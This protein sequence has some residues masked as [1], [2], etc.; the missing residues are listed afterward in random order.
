MGYPNKIGISRLKQQF[1]RIGARLVVT[2]HQAQRLER[3][4]RNRTTAKQ[5][6]WR[7]V[8][9]FSSNVRLDAEGEHFTMI[10]GDNSM[11]PSGKASV[12]GPDLS[13]V[14]VLDIRPKDR[15]LL[16]QVVIGEGKDMQVDKLLMGHDE[17]H[18]FIAQATGST[19]FEA[20]ENLK[21]DIVRE[22]Q[23]R[24]NVKRSKRN[25]RK[26]AAFIRQGEWFFLP[27]PDFFPGKHTIVSANEPLRRGAGKPHMA[28]E[29]CRMGGTTVMFN[30]VYAPEG[31]SMDAYNKLRNE[32]SEDEDFRRSGAW[33]SMTRDAIV[34]VRG[35]IRHP[36]HKTLKLRGWY[37]VV[38]NTEQV[39]TGGR[40]RTV[41]FLD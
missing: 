21:P 32:L 7:K 24:V 16:L 5:M 27:E 13:K 1:E 12:E 29:C 39:R 35:K 38:P 26:N 17:R 34:Y 2:E 8:S 23:K 10:I 14:Q 33:R 6:E 4:F 11:V 36:D 18:W 15:H 3:P 19:V 20:K 37:L 28:E 30:H 41:A 9:P 31:I 22:R 40:L 25:K